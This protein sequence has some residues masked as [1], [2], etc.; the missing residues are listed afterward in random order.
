MDRRVAEIKQG[1]QE[2]IK[3][4]QECGLR[5]GR[6]LHAE[7]HQYPEGGDPK[8]TLHNQLSQFK[9]SRPARAKSRKGIEGLDTKDDSS[10]ESPIECYIDGTRLA[11][12][13]LHHRI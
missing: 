2:W 9:T 10:I 5:R 3:R 13:Q 4:N 11:Q 1:K 12:S 8:N 6:K 7:V